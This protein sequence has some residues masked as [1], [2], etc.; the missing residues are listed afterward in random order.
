MGPDGSAL[1]I[2]DGALMARD[3]ATMELWKADPGTPAAEVLEAMVAAGYE[4]APIDEHPLSRFVSRD[5]IEPT[6]APIAQQAEVITAAIAIPG[7]LGLIST[8]IELRRSPYLFVYGTS[9]V[10][11]IVTLADLQKPP[12]SVAVLTLILATEQGLESLAR[13]VDGW[14]ARL[15]PDRLD[16]ARRVLEERRRFDVEIDLLHCL[17]IHDLLRI[18]EKDRDLREQLGHSRDSFS[19]WSNTLRQARDRLAHAGDLLSAFGDP[20]QATNFVE[21]LRRFAEAVWRAARAQ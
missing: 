2:A 14:E 4:A 12:V 10:Q 6:S 5:R 9:E 15:T 19:T 16:G 3:F 1:R 21:D 20:T 17:M 18:V 8:V 13:G 7:S 11:G